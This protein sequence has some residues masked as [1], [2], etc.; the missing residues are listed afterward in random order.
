MKNNVLVPIRKELERKEQQ[1]K[2]GNGNEML[3]MI[4]YIKTISLD[5]AYRE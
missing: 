1:N 3:F 4:C 5:I 2:L